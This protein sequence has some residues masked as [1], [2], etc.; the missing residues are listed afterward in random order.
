MDTD[1]TPIFENDDENDGDD[2]DAGNANDDSD[3]D[4]AGELR[5]SKQFDGMAAR[6]GGIRDL[7]PSQ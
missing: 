4:A 3:N 6:N 1:I 5:F 2:D 7:V